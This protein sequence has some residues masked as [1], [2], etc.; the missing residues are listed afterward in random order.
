MQTARYLL[1]MIAVGS[2]GVIGVTPP[3]RADAISLNMTIRDFCG[4]N[5]G[6]VNCPTGYSPN[7]DFEN[8]IADDRGIVKASLGAD[9]T[10]DY[11]GGAHPT[12]YGTDSSPALGTLTTAQYFAQWYH[13]TPGYNQ[14]TTIAI[15]LTNNGSGVYTYDN[16]NF[17]PIDNQLLGNEGQSHN[18]SFTGQ[19]H[20]TFTYQA[21]QTFGFTGDDDVWV[22]IN[23]G[24]VI[25]LGGVHGPESQ[26]VSL[27]TLG[28]TVGN[29]Y[30][31]DL[32][33]AERHTSGSDIRI[34]TSIVLNTNPPAGV[35]EPATLALLGMGL[36]ALGYSRKKKRPASDQ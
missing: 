33:F 26:A 36:A 15:S 9:G 11:A 34:D 31:F 18:F 14:A 25:D 17:F 1:L 32:F 35:P 29:T 13:P 7:P 27:D 4:W 16:S 5:F 10:P 22:F 19:L 3:A 28:L 30:D 8:N 20:T 21:G 6:A 24:L 2:V 23:H 12:L